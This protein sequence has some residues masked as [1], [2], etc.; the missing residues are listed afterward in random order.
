MRGGDFRQKSISSCRKSRLGEGIMRRR[1]TQPH[2]HCPNKCAPTK[3]ALQKLRR[4]VSQQYQGAPPLLP[5][6]PCLR[7][8][9]TLPSHSP[10]AP[11]A[12]EP[13]APIVRQNRSP[14]PPCLA[15][16]AI[17]PVPRLKARAATAVL[18]C[19]KCYPHLSSTD[20]SQP[21]GIIIT[22][23]YVKVGGDVLQEGLLLE[24]AGPEVGSLGEPLR[25]NVQ[26]RG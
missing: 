7:T 10:S 4:G 19:E 13:P 22:Y 23:L 3:F 18:S 24:E 8:R 12:A 2:P 5:T 17:T 1:C 25:V 6:C 26:H 9:I 20:P 11:F 15:E 16:I 21:P 14:P